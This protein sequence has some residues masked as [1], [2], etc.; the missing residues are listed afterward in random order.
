MPRRRAVWASWNYMATRDGDRHAP[1]Q[2]SYWLNRL[3]DIDAR[4]D[5]FV[6]LNPTRPPANA[7]ARFDYEDGAYRRHTVHFIDE[8]LRLDAD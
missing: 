7:L 5:V 8:G 6:T 1:P 3:Q 4:E 2:V